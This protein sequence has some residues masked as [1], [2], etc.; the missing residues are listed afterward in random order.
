VNEE[1]DLRSATVDGEAKII[2][3]FTK[4]L[5]GLQETPE[6]LAKELYEVLKA[7]AAAEKAEKRI[8]EFF[9]TKYGNGSHV[10]GGYLVEVAPTEGRRSVKVE[11]FEKYIVSILT[12]EALEDARKACISKGEEG[13]RVTVKALSQNASG[14]LSGGVP[15]ESGL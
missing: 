3:H 14:D 15:G 2:S 7:K 10:I 6:Q 11:T 12:K 13:S 4:D 5:E 9:K 8:K 1:I